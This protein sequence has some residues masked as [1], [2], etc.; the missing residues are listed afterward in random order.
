MHG[1]IGLPHR[2]PRSQA[3]REAQIS[4]QD[5]ATTNKDTTIVNLDLTLITHGVLQDK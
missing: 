3:R 2:G 1:L 4:L 5:S